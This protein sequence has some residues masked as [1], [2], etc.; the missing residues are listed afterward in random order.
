MIKKITKILRILLSDF[1]YFIGLALNSDKILKKAH[2]VSG[3]RVSYASIRLSSA[4]NSQAISDVG[5]LYYDLLKRQKSENIASKE[6]LNY[7]FLKQLRQS[8]YNQEALF[9]D[10][11]ENFLRVLLNYQFISKSQLYQDIFVLFCLSERKQGYFVEIGVGDGIRFSNSYLLEKEFE[12]DGLLIEPNRFFIEEIKKHDRRATLLPYA[13]TDKSGESVEFLDVLDNREVSTIKAYKESSK[14][15]R[16]NNQVYKV[17][18]LTFSDAL[19]KGNAPKSIDYLSI[20]T[21]G[22]ELEILQTIDFDKYN[23][24]VLTIEHNNHEDK[25]DRIIEIMTNNGYKRVFE[26]LSSFDAWFVRKDMWE[27]LNY[28]EPVK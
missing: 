1:F 10:I 21:E 27:C 11:H 12:W 5:S 4:G 22:S 8:N 14:H 26:E 19:K 15:N 13:I 9:L 23:I 28:G 24:S 2:Q 6:F 18:T 16:D 3:Q 25:K 7:F 17:E 20:D